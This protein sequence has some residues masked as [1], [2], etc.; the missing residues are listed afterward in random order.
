MWLRLLPVV[1]V[2]A[3]AGIYHVSQKSLSRGGNPWA[4]LTAAYFIAFFATRFLWAPWK[5][6]ISEAAS[7]RS[8]LPGIVLLA[9]SC[10]GIAAGYLLAYRG[11][12][13]VST[14]F[15]ITSTGSFL[16]VM[17]VGLFLFGEGVSFRIFAGVG[18]SL[19]GFLLMHWK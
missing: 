1:L 6:T 11:G 12:W 13:N 4:I 18:L 8:F 14:L 7:L 16:V 5:S 17:S 9:L 2:V 19:A 10:V 3:S 15:T